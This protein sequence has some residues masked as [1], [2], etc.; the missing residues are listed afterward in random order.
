MNTIDFQSITLSPERIVKPYS[1]IEHIPFAFLLIQKLKPKT[2][3]ELGAHTGNSYNAFCQAV[4]CYGNNTLC[5]AVDTWEGDTQAGFYNESVFQDLASYQ[6]NKYR[7]FSTLI[8]STFD[9]ALGQFEDQ[10]IDLLHID[11][12]HTYD[13][14]KHDFETWLPKMSEKGVILFH[15]TEVYRDDFGVWK[16]WKEIHEHYPSFNFKHGYGLGVLLV[17]QKCRFVF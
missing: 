13:A 14:V 12:L 5:Y 11:G 17:G 1:W 6:N 10:S 8:K 15:D 9:K 3:V 2:L 7:E 16:L 4:K